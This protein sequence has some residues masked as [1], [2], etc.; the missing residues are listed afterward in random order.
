M[1]LAIFEGKIKNDSTYIIQQ[2]SR[3]SKGSNIERNRH[4]SV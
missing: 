1:D 4:G 2:I 3:K